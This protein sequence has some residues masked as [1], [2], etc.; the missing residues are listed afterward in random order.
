MLY[1]EVTRR[2]G[3]TPREVGFKLPSRADS[4]SE[5]RRRLA[6]L[7]RDLDHP[8]LARVRLLVTEL[9]A[10][11]FK[12]ARGQEIHCDVVVSDG[13]VRAE[14][15]DGGPGFE[16]PR[17]S[18]QLMRTDGWGL[19]L[20]RRIADRWGTSDGGTRVWFEIDQRAS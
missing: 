6:E 19:V 10:N 12:Y 3:S 16:V 15:A 2:G 13:L 20:V 8:T 18:Q 17:G 1:V 11:S 9:V 7:G 14:V 4:A 5:A